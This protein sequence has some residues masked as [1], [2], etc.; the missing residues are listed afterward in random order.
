MWYKQYGWKANPFSIKTSTD[1]IGLE[2]KK[3][4]LLNYIRAGD[5]CFLNGPTGVGKTSL[6]KW[7]EKNLKHHKLIYIDAAGIQ[8]GFSLAK[9]LKNKTNFLGKLTGKEFPKN[10]VVLV[11]ESQDCNPEFLKAL[12]LHWDHNHIKS[13]VV[14]Q[15]NPELN[16]SES[17][18]NRI[19]NRIIPIGRLSKSEGYELI[20]LRCNNKNPFDKSAIEAILEYSHC[21]PRKILE[22]C[23]ISCMRLQGKNPINAFDIE[24][25]LRSHQQKKIEENEIP[26]YSEFKRELEETEIKQQEIK[27]PSPLT[28]QSQEAININIKLSPMEKSILQHLQASNKTSQMLALLLKTSEGSVGKQLSNLMKKS[29]IKITKLER[30]K[31]YGLWQESPI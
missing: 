21:I 25:I 30:P 17:F 13:I 3:Q 11:D 16:F 31:E 9:Y 24:E 15:I 8:E 1:L 5:V 6:L 12:K 14:T 19:G 28:P 20:S 23:E 2:G 22:T 7:L 29:L 27:I 4:E 26:Q 18:R 10:T